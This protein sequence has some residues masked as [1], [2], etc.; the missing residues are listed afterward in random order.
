MAKEQEQNL[1]Q[2]IRKDAKNCFVEALNDKFQ[3][4]RLHLFFATYDVSKPVKQ[5]QTNKINIY[6]PI[7]EVTELCRQ[8]SS[9]E[10][11]YMLNKRKENKD[12]TP[13]YESLGG[14]S[15]KRLRALGNER[16][17]KKSLSRMA[18]IL[19]GQKSDILFVAQSGPGEEN[20]K[21]LIVP[22]YGGQPENKVIVSMTFE[23]FSELLLVSKTHYEAWLTGWYLHRNAV[24]QAGRQGTA[25]SQKK[26]SPRAVEEPVDE[27]YGDEYDEYD[28]VA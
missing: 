10:F 16:K 23:A 15:A 28:V 27:E 18:G 6:L 22:K 1:N 4:G 24:M 17:D 25:Q 13:L 26:S 3:N 21:G 9:G 19:A 20:D 7:E 5:R 11:R 12:N 2:I 8:L 14:T